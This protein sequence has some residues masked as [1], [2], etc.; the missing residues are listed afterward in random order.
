MPL[1]REVLKGCARH[2]ACRRLGTGLRL[3]SAMV[4]GREAARGGLQAAL[5][6]GAE[7]PVAVPTLGQGSG[8][9]WPGLGA[10][11]THAGGGC[12]QTYLLADSRRDMGTKSGAP[13]GSPL[14]LLPRNPG[15]A[16]WGPG[17]GI[18]LFVP[19]FLARHSHPQGPGRPVPDAGGRTRAS[20]SASRQAAGS[21]TA[22]G[23]RQR[24]A[25]VMD[26]L[27]ITARLCSGC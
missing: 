4:Q 21:A 10:G 11:I 23:A 3:G 26:G 15:T 20:P 6:R 13:W 19:Q 16:G 8:P 5:P 7:P 12:S 27:F 18:G 9:A 2:W 17:T 25:A 22:A 24:D 1:C 14:S